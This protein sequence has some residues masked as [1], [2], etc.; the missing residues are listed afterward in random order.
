MIRRSSCHGERPVRSFPTY[1]GGIAGPYP[2]LQGLDKALRSRLRPTGCSAGLYGRFALGAHAEREQFLDLVKSEL[3]FDPVVARM[4]VAEGFGAVGGTGLPRCPEREREFRMRHSIHAKSATD[5]GRDDPQLRLWDGE[6]SRH[7]GATDVRALHAGTKHVAV[8][9]RI[10]IGDGGARLH[11]RRCR[12]ADVD[13]VT[14]D[15][16]G[17]GEGPLCSSR[18]PTSVRTQRLLGHSDQTSGAP[19]RLAALRSAAAGSGAYP[20][21]SCSAASFACRRVLAITAATGSPTKRVLP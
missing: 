1:R 6:D 18:R 14:D 13:L 8:L 16:R 17:R 21:P 15:M 3:G 19:G 7:L 12:P 4:L 20:I 10:V 5:I 2:S 9:A 11:G